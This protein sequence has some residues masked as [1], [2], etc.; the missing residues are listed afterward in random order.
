MAR[1]ETLTKADLVSRLAPVFRQKGYEG[2]SLADLAAVA[3]LG[4]AALYHRF[5]AGKAAMAAAVLAATERQMAEDVLALLKT[6]ASPAKRLSAMAAALGTFYEGGAKPCLMD[7]FS[8]AG[9]PGDIRKDVRRGASEW[10]AAIAAALVEAG[11]APAQARR[12]AQD[13]VI[14]VEGALVVSRA[15][16]DTA[17]FRRAL[18]DFADDLLASG[19]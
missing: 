5:P 1:P 6:R 10:I 18:K 4:K 16:G 9:T 7:I 15:L 13:A 11:I 14:R 17:P 8:V 12:R 2:A 3:G 19:R